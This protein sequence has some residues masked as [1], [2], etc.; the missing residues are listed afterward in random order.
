MIRAKHAWACSFPVLLERFAGELNWLKGGGKRS[1]R[2]RTHQST[3]CSCLPLSLQPQKGK[4]QPRFGAVM[5]VP[6]RMCSSQ[7]RILQHLQLERRLLPKTTAAS[8]H[9][10][11]RWRAE[12]SALLHLSLGL[13]L[14]LKV[15]PTLGPGWGPVRSRRK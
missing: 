6:G 2:V 12:W 4:N 1:G 5:Y 7:G 10:E 9:P 15:Y 11:C 14:A 8:V 13:P 3:P